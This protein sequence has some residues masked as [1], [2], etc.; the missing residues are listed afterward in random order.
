[1]A[2]NKVN[3]ESYLTIVPVFILSRIQWEPLL[4]SDSQNVDELESVRL[5]LSSSL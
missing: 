1:M 5:F 4:P 3:N 2:V